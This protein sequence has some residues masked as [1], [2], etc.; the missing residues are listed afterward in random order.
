MAPLS[1]LVPFW[2]P[3]P[4]NGGNPF[5]STLLSFSLLL[6][7]LWPCQC[8]YPRAGWLADIVFC[9]IIAP[10]FQNHLKAHFHTPASVVHIIP[11]SLM[12]THSG[13]CLPALV[14]VE[15]KC[16][17]SAGAWGS[18]M[19]KLPNSKQREYS[20]SYSLSLLFFPFSQHVKDPFTNPNMQSSRFWSS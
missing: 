10:F 19:S 18:S 9:G 16:R 7:C 1:S 8:L 2:I 11:W 4:H 14:F 6:L 15:P 17:G 5:K 13:Q 12:A 20:L 3:P